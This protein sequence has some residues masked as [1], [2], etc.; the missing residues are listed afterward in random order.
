MV[1]LWTRPNGADS[2]RAKQSD[3]V[4]FIYIYILY[5][6]KPQYVLR[7]ILEMSSLSSISIYYLIQT[8]ILLIF[9]F[10]QIIMCL[11]IFNFFLESIINIVFDNLK[12]KSQLCIEDAT[13]QRRT[14]GKKLGKF[15]PQK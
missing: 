11:Y 2:G 15:G 7:V 6:T 3:K 4:L 8:F 9:Q 5:I 14:K 13:A 1:L 10:A 12:T